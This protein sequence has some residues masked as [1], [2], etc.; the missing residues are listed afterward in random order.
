M[1]EPRAKGL[2]AL[3]VRPRYA[4]PV[5]LVG[6]RAIVTGAAPGSLGYATART[7]ASWGARVLVSTRGD[8]AA[9]AARLAAELRADGRPADVHGLPL[10]LAQAASVARFADD[11]QAALD[12][13]LDLLINNAGIHL[14]L[15]STWKTAPLSED[16]HELHWRT[17]YL[18]TMQLTL[19]LLPA[20]RRAAAACGEARVVNVVSMLHARGR[21]DGLFAPL[22]P[23]NAWVAYGVSKLALVHATAELQRRYG[24]D[25]LGAYCLH[26]GAVYTNI[27]AKGLAGQR[28]VEALRRTL[29]PVEAFFL[30]TPDEGAQTSLYC[31]TQPDLA[32]GGYFRDCRPARP[33]ADA[34][35][36]AVAARLWTQTLEQLA[37]LR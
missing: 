27:A 37:A 31:A 2:R 29:A 12:G 19:A 18:G 6:R 23:Y 10:D 5:D 16:G 17:N 35:D 11:S 28:T 4:T 1:P 25:G 30:R 24:G 26:P 36:A 33:S 13:R 8:A 7:L 32:G 14:D 3:L 22:Q 9:L 20:L 21:N 15:M 34:R